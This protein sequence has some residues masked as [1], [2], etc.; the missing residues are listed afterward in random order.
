MQFLQFEFLNKLQNA[1]QETS[2]ETKG[3]LHGTPLVTVANQYIPFRNRN[4]VNLSV[5]NIPSPVG[6]G[7][8]SAASVGANPGGVACSNVVS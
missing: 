3:G 8:L 4:K 5:H 2:T 1:V 6:C 7:K